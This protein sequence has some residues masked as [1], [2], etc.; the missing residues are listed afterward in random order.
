M[1][2]PQGHPGAHF[3]ERGRPQAAIDVNEVV[4]PRLGEMRSV[5]ARLQREVNGPRKTWRW[6]DAASSCAI[7]DELDNKLGFGASLLWPLMVFFPRPCYALGATSDKTLVITKPVTW[8][9][10]AG[11]LEVLPRRI[12]RQDAFSHPRGAKAIA[13]NPSAEELVK[14]GFDPRAL[15]ERLDQLDEHVGNHIA[16]QTYVPEFEYSVLDDD[17]WDD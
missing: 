14:M 8:A 15:E 12:E 2:R 11:R 13:I 10:S 3:V 6:L 1:I 4:S 5:L 7:Y 17:G 16:G 9:W